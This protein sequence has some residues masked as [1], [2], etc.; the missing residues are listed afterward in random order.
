MEQDR[1]QEEL[2]GAQVEEIDPESERDVELEHRDSR[3]ASLPHIEYTT[4]MTSAR[5]RVKEGNMP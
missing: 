2:G 4:S 1:E 5:P 3:L